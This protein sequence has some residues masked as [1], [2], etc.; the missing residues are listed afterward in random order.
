M[1][2]EN[3]IFEGP[4]DEQMRSRE[5]LSAYRIMCDTLFVYF[6]DELVR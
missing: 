2:F 4:H 5:T 6:V 1:L 3:L